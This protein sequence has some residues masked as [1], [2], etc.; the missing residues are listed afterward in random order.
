MSAAK[1][2]G[3]IVLIN[4]WAL[5]GGGFL[6]GHRAEILGIAAG[7]GGLADALAQWAVGDASIVSLIH[8]VSQNWALIAGG[9]GLATLGAKLERTR[10]GPKKASET[11]SEIADRALRR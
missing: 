5:I 7:I 3:G 11:V 6:K 10:I 2:A 9:F 8:A 4:L 1:L